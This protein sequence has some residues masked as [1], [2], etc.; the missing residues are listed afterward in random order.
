MTPVRLEPA[1]ARSQ[2]KHS[3][4]DQ[5]RSLNQRCI[6]VGS[7]CVCVCGGGGGACMRVCV[8]VYVCV[9]YV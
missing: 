9:F 8:Y 2:V 1:A 7:V 3:K 5:L 4:T 6:D